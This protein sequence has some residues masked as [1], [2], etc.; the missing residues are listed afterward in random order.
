MAVYIIFMYIMYYEGAEKPSLP[1]LYEKVT[2][3]FASYWKDIGVFLELPQETLRTIE[4][5][6]RNCIKCCNAMLDE[7]LETTPTASWS[8][9]V[10]ALES[11][12]RTE[13]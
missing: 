9:L 1:E 4:Q 8:V 11:A 10:E 5:D 6:N 3:H 7:W 12:K 13:C 2:P